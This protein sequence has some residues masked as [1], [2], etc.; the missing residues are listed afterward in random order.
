MGMKASKRLAVAP[1]EDW[2]P[3]FDGDT[4]RARLYLLGDGSWRVCVW[5]ADDTGV[6]L[7]TPDE[8][9]A[10][11]VYAGLPSV[12]SKEYLRGVGFKAA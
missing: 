11:A 2:Y 4:V 8:S 10:R 3:N 7:D 9:F 12:V 5:G 1:G 6:E